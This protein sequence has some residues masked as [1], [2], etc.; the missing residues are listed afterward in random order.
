MLRTLMAVALLT[1]LGVWV[2]PVAYHTVLG[3][4]NA[5]ATPV[6]AVVVFAYACSL[7]GSAVGARMRARA[8]AREAGHG[9]RDVDPN[10]DP[11][12]KSGGT[13]YGV[14]PESGSG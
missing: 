1:V 12:G 10:P 13:P 9:P 4:G 11:I 3:F 2:V 8:R 7:A 5:L 6:G 14:T